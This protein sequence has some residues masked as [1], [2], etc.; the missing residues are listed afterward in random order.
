M[1]M[2]EMKNNVEQLSKLTVNLEAARDELEAINKEE[3]LLEWE[4]SAFPHL[5]TMFNMKDPYEK[6]WNTA[7]LF[8][9]KSD[10]WQNGEN[11]K[12]PLRETTSHARPMMKSEANVPFLR[13]HETKSVQQ[14]PL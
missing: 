9:T 2:D 14:W 12:V 3:V 7:L 5:Q 10:E 13:P 11:T 1:S 6:L 8:T 4:A